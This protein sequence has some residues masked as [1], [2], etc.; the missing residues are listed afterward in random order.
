MAYSDD[1]RTAILEAVRNARKKKIKWPDILPLAK[2]QGFKGALGA[3]QA[4]TAKGKLRGRKVGAKVGRPK[5]GG[6]GPG[7]PKGSTNKLFSFMVG[8]GMKPTVAGGL[9]GIEI[10]VR[11]EVDARLRNARDAAINAF[12]AALGS[13]H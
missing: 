5:S 11:R 12:N 2:V 3:L 4:F 8:N 6:R 9:A 1:E 13:S 7:R 10:I